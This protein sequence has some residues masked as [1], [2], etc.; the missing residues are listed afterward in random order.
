MPID[1]FRDSPL[2]QALK[3]RKELQEKLKETIQSIEKIEEWLKTYRELSIGDADSKKEDSRS[4][5]GLAGWGQ[6]QQVFESLVVGVLRDVGRPMRSGE[7]ID[8]F[9]KRGHPLKGND[10]RTAWNRLWNARKRDVLTSDRSLGYW[11]AGEPLTEQAQLSAA[12]I[13]RRERHPTATLRNQNKGKK[14]GRA[15]VLTDE[16]VDAGER[17]LLAGKSRL[18]VAAAL[19]GVS[20]GTI[21]AYFP[22]GIRGLKKKY[23]D[24]VIPKRTYRPRPGIKGGRPPLLSVLEAQRIVKM[25]DEGKG[26][27]EIAKYM[28]IKRGTVYRYLKKYQTT[29]E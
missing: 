13:A 2:A 15:R 21:N 25:K 23:P 27:D 7:L 14:K 8:E 9:R 5:V 1:D 10:V 3:K 26:A 20:Q 12:L 17:M 19:G 22:G 11:I 4:D 24:V 6:A 16:Q 28:G 18:E 29:K